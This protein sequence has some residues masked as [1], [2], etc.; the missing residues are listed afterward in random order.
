MLLQASD[1]LGKIPSFHF[2]L[3]DIGREVIAANFS[4]TFSAYSIAFT[5]GDAKGCAGLEA[6]MGYG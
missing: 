2:D 5:K 6:E 1:T 3:V 4:A